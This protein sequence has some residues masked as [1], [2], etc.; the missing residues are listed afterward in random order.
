VH[1]TVIMFVLQLATSDP[2]LVAALRNLAVLGAHQVDDIEVAAFLVRDEDGLVSCVIWP[3]NGTRRSAHYEGV[4]PNRTVALAH[5]HPDSAPQ[6]SRADIA[7]ARRIGFPI[8]VVTR[9]D[10]YWIDPAS[11]QS[12]H[13]I[14]RQN[15]T[16]KSS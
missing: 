13:L 16:K 11:G 6:P 2:G 15:W 4:I 1:V 14:R 12:L 5:T 8:Y 7:E 10:L 9:W 3:H